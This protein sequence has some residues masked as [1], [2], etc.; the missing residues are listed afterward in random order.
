MAGIQAPDGTPE[1]GRGDRDDEDVG[2]STTSPQGANLDEVQ[3][4][5]EDRQAGLYLFCFVLCCFV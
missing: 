1:F 4:E 3:M 5:D 2:M